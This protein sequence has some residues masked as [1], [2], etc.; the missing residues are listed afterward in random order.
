MY[1]IVLN[2]GIFFAG[3]KIGW[4][5][6]HALPEQAEGLRTIIKLRLISW[7]IRRAPTSLYIG[8]E[9]YHQSGEKIPDF[10]E[11]AYLMSFS[12]RA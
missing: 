2:S 3:L 12:V 1:A 4:W 9:G 7:S 6:L 10:G 11:I 8:F 5:N